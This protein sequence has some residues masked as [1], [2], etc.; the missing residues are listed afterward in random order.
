MSLPIPGKPV[1]G[2]KS[3]NHLMALFDLLGRSWSMGIIWRLQEG[4]CTFRALQDRC[5]SIS[6][7]T[8]NKRLKEL[9]QAFLIERTVDGYSLTDKGKEIFLLLKPLEFW[10]RNWA[11]E[12]ENKEK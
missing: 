7:T 10:A 3:G 6:P 11:K 2:S 1:R 12:F 5:E 8:L 4:A 9:T